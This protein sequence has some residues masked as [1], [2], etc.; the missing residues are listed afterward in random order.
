[1]KH[2][3]LTGLLS[4]AGALTAVAVE[5]G[6]QAPDFKG[7]NLKSEEVSLE[8]L[9]GKVIVLEWINFG[10][11][12]VKKHYESGNMPMLQKKYTDK[13]VVWISVNSSAEGKQGHMETEKMAKKAEAEGNAATHFIMD[14]DGTIGR[15]YGA[16]VTPHMIIIGKDGKVAYNGA[17]D[18]MATVRVA[19]IETAKPFFANALDSVLAGKPVE[20]AKTK[21]YGCGV[22]Y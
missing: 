3:L 15:A 2:I 17:I 13:D 5:P 9:K 7:K 12:F 18:S 1:M 6:A 8:S 10:C 14:S 11:P 21:P 16:E 22:K 20:N 19:D 4:L